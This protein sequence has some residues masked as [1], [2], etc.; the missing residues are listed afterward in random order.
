[1]RDCTNLL[2]LKSFLSL[3]DSTPAAPNLGG[4]FWNS[5]LS[6]KYTV[7][8]RCQLKKM[9]TDNSMHMKTCLLTLQLKHWTLVS[10]SY[11]LK[12][13]SCVP[14][15]INKNCLPDNFQVDQLLW[16]ST[17]TPL[18]KALL[19]KFIGHTLHYCNHTCAQPSWQSVTFLISAQVN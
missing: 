12:Y 17:R 16:A 5:A 8:H 11:Y 13:S 2:R 10:D 19:L 18:F 15:E 4:K 1:M 6:T 14:L 9:P 7:T 3:K